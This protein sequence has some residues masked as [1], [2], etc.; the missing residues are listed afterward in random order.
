MSSEVDPLA[1]TAHQS[2]VRTASAMMR[3]LRESQLEQASCELESLRVLT[4]R[5]PDDAD[6]LFFRV[7]IAIQ[8]G[9][10]REALQYLSELG[11][12]SH[13]ELRVLCL[14]SLQDP[15]WE[16]LANEVASASESA[17]AQAMS[18]ML[19]CHAANRHAS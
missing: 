4:G 12:G 1:N 8:R 18:Q 6:I 5:E 11:E 19:A 9:Q 3:A 17:A 15:Y 13:P 10:A 16:G 7:F 2:V 14:Y